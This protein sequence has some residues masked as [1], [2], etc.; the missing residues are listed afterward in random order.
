MIVPVT[1][2][3][4]PAN[5][6]MVGNIDAIESPRMELPTHN[7]GA[8]ARPRMMRHR[9]AKQPARSV[10]RIVRGEASGGPDAEQSSNG[11]Q[12][13]EGGSQIGGSDGCRKI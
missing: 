12:S 2:N 10:K 1:R 13:P 5:I 8:E 3:L 4:F 7:S 11:E 9:L 6:R